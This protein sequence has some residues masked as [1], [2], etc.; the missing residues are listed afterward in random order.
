MKKKEKVI[1]VK[2]FDKARKLMSE[3]VGLNVTK[4]AR[5]HKNRRYKV[6]MMAQLDRIEL[7]FHLHYVLFF[8][9][10][11]NFETDWYTVEFGY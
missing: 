1:S 2:D 9:S 5:L 4:L 10:L 11:W 8:L 3:I 6:R 7:P